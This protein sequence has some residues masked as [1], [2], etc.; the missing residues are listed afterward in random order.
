MERSKAAERF[1]EQLGSVGTLPGEDVWLPPWLFRHKELLDEERGARRVNRETLANTVN[2]IHFLDGHV[3]V[4]LRHP[5]YDENVLL[6]A[7]PEPCLGT[8]LTCHWPKEEVS[9][10]HLEGYR[11]L[12]III[13][14]G[15]SM[16][17]IPAFP[18]ETGP[19]SFTLDLPDTG[20]AVGERKIRRYPCREVRVELIQSGFLARGELLDFS[21]AGFRV[22]VTPDSP[23]SFRWFNEDEP[24]TV[25]LVS[26]HQMVFSG[27]CRCIRNGGE[28]S[29]GE[30]V[31]YPLHEKINRFRKKQIRNV[32]Q[33]LTPSPTL[34]YT[35][36]ILKKRIQ[37]A[38]SDISTSGFCVL[39]DRDDAVLMPGMVLPELTV[40]FAG[41]QGLKCSAQ[42]IY[43]LEEEGT[44]NRC[45][46]AI[47]DMDISDYTRLTHILTN[48]LD[49]HAHIS[50][51]ID[52]DALWEFF[53][54]TGFLYPK[55][56][57]LIQS[58]RERFKETYK[59]LY[60]GNPEIARHF[61]YQRGGRIFGHI[62]M[63]RAYEKAWMIHHHAAQAMENRRTGFMVLKQIMHYLNDM[64]R[65]PS[66]NMDYVICY[67]RPENK[68]PDRVF[69]GFAR[70][71][72]NPQG[73]SM[74]LFSYLPYTGL[75]MGAQL[76]KEWSLH[77]CTP[78]EFWEL[79]RFYTHHSG[80]LLPD[81]LGLK[82][83]GRCGQ[84]LQESY[85]SF[86][87]L[88]KWKAYALSHGG[89]LKA[90]LIM[91]QT[92]LGFN[93]SELLNGIK[94]I[95]TEPE[96]LPWNTLSVAIARLT[97]EYHM[98]R[99]PVLFYP[100]TYVETMGV[101]HEKQYQMWILNVQYGNEYL[102]YMQKRFRISY[103]QARPPVSFPCKG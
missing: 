13:D 2:H 100:Y 66:A 81:V 92:D 5:R 27:P 24:A 18:R 14:D 70:S 22:S 37:I 49:P 12:Y 58:H 65:L 71:L 90:V 68:F 95:V 64:H 85:A 3:L 101:P 6:R 55:K 91:N 79:N 103:R 40:D 59:K 20:Y 77:E 7:L 78:R 80:G 10:L 11:F 102:E 26:D 44:G 31:L 19:E 36:P 23:C 35:H 51:D 9:G 87:L 86:G 75:S 45:G 46:L 28:L 41:S 73:C 38:V 69:G 56:Y 52:M 42:V 60:Q 57:R 15:R 83:G 61:I 82:Q 34:V 32:R 62:A 93:L 94:V 76:P 48:A 30:F 16:V 8:T 4:L 84:R 99:V 72:G 54:H 43:C 50:S 96:N 63:V 74:D 67:F 17:L 39:E 21:P 29:E 89:R 98:E 25:H 53:F 33:T 47:L 97:G 88:R 1:A